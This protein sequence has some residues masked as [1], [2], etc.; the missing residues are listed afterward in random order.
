MPDC[1][2]RNEFRLVDEPDHLPE[3]FPQ[4]H[5][6]AAQRLILFLCSTSGTLALV[7]RKTSFKDENYHFQQP[8]AFGRLEF[9]VT[10]LNFPF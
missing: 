3:N 1:K 5:L 9:L 10:G 4:K 6:L 7:A 8:L 2:T